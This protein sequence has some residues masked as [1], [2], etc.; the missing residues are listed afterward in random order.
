MS[1]ASLST[2][3]RSQDRFAFYANDPPALAFDATLR[4]WIVFD[5]DLAVSV[6]KDRR[7]A[8]VDYRGA[9]KALA[10]AT[11]IPLDNSDHAL[12]YVPIARDGA[13][14]LAQRKAIAA[15]IAATQQL[16]TVESA[17]AAE[18]LAARLA[19]A[20]E[21]DIMT[22]ILVPMV[23]RV[24]S[25]LVGIPIAP[26]EPA[27]AMSRV[28]DRLLGVSRHRE[29]D[30]S[31]G[32]ARARVRDAAGPDADESARGHLLSLW[33]LG[34]DA[35]I[36]TL[37]MSMAKLIERHDGE[38]LSAIP[39]PDTPPETGVPYVARIVG[40]DTVLAGKQLRRNDRLRVVLQASAYSADL[41]DHTRLFG[42]GAHSCLGKAISL[43]AWRALTTAI[44]RVD[45]RVHWLETRLRPHDH[46]FLV[47]Q[48]LRVET[49]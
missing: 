44:S 20:S 5:P 49:R 47:L 13:T 46:L 11:G 48:S 30:A 1:I 12:A 9:N 32:E 38:H 42:A 21:H 39:Y 6:L 2:I 3:H 17:A 41:S 4:S 15:R 24:M 25:A 45:R 16:A 8:A 18:A 22:D 23:N 27:S 43:A 34:Y 10:E 29:V 28:F 36:G 7:F 40:E 35:L 37:G 31:I 26:D 33:I 19:E 14:H